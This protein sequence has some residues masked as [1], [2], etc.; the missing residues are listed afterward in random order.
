MKYPYF[1]K[2]ADKLRNV[3]SPNPELMLANTTPEIVLDHEREKKIG[4]MR[5]IS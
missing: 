5:M 4:T 1:L 3:I 2:K